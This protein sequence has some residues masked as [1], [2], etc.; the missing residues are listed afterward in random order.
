MIGL[1]RLDDDLYEENFQD[2]TTSDQEILSV[3]TIIDAGSKEIKGQVTTQTP[4]G[5]V[6]TRNDTNSTN[7]YGLDLDNSMQEDNEIDDLDGA[8]DILREILKY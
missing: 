1:Q 3:D 4:K 5:N 2:P 6:P 7:E 8:L